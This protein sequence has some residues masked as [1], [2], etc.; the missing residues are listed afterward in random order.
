MSESSAESART[1]A[2]QR[3]LESV[4]AELGSVT[5][6]QAL[7]SGWATI[8]DLAQDQVVFKVNRGGGTE[9]YRGLR[10]RDVQ[11]EEGALARLNSPEILTQWQ[12]LATSSFLTLATSHFAA[13]LTW[14]E[15]ESDPDMTSAVAVPLPATADDLARAL[16]EGDTLGNR[17]Q[18]REW[19]LAAEDVDFTDEQSDRLAPRLLE[20]AGELRTSD[21]SE[22]EPAV[23]AAIRRGASMLRPGQ[24]SALLPLLEPGYPIE[25]SLATLKMLGRIF[26]A[27][28]PKSTDAYPR[29]ARAVRVIGES[30]LNRYALAVTQSAAMAQLA[31][32]ALAAM[33]SADAVET[34]RTAE[35]LG[36][37]WFARRCAREIRRL[38]EAWEQR[39]VSAGAAPRRLLQQVLREL[40]A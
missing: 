38:D 9:V 13:W 5:H 21:D 32:Y 1:R 37:S 34:A 26:E 27:Q 6:D 36:V 11:S 12:Q 28:P 40:K 23:S 24:A 7:P 35:R 33:A 10:A 19:I 8:E 2:S 15:P 29:L 16:I 17:S 14:T 30:L 3:L 31:I 20:L 4:L 39:R 22:D 25:T 18:I